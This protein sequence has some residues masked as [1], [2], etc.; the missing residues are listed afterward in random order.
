VIRAAAQI[1][2]EGVARPILLGKP[3]KIRP[4]AEALGIDL[5]GVE[6]IHPTLEDDRR[7]SY[8]DELHEMR[9]RKGLTLSEARSNMYKTIYFGS[10]MVRRGDAAALV[11]GVDSNY[12]EVLRPALEVVGTAP[13]VSRVA[14]LYMMALRDREPLF[15][16]DTTVNIDPTPATLAE[17]A[18]LSA[19]FV[20]DL[21]ITPR[22]AMLSFSNFGSA[23][24]PASL[25]VRE[26]VE[27]VKEMA[28]E[29]EVDGEMQA[30][31]AVSREILEGTYPFS[32]L[33]QPA[34]ILIFPNLASANVSYKLMN[35]LGGAEGI[36]PILLGMAD[37]VHVLQR[38]ST[39]QDV[40]NLVTIASVDA[41]RRT[42]QT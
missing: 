26:A 5:E 33:K 25:R 17:V 24:H 30:D 15:F 40:V 11:A 37:P 8:A 20:R 34:N 14:G 22:L 3:H 19:R 16:A 21:G 2:E 31:T 35:E 10:M 12:P 39:T 18:L 4:R 29:L 13:G 7:Y 9:R 38:G 28:P 41:Q 32:D 42:P 36:G 23:R 6:I 27:R 1:V